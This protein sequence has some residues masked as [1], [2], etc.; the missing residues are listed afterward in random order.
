M[1]VHL[2]GQNNAK[3]TAA[4]REVSLSQR[5]EYPWNGRVALTV[6]AGAP[7]ALTLHMRVPGWCGR[8]SLKVNGQPVDATLPLPRNPKFIGHASAACSMR[9][10]FHSPG[11]H[12]V[13]LVPVAGPV[14]PPIIVV[15]PP[16]S[17]S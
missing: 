15:M 5:T 11:V 2:Y 13:A 4:G 8:W 17:A 7:T 1:W 6:D 12:V 9:A 3:V 14:P 10:M 16:L